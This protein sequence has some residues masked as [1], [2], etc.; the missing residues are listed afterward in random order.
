MYFSFFF[1]IL[2][3]ILL[4][5]LGLLFLAIKSFIYSLFFDELY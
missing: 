3:F 5:F 4:F 1:R 2:L